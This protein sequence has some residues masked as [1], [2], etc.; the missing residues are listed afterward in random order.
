LLA[1]LQVRFGNDAA[2]AG[3]A[4]RRIPEMFPNTA[5]VEPALERLAALCGEMKAHQ[6]TALKTLGRYEKHIGLKPTGG[7][8]A[9]KG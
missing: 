4:L 8:P 5:L 2:A 9:V 3:A 1:D 6:K 7:Q